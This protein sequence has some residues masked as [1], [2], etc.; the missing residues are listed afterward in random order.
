VVAE[1]G[2]SYEPRYVTFVE[3][4]PRTAM[5]KIDKKALR[6]AAGRQSELHRD[7]GQR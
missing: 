5:G 6:A 2:E 3:T 7:G 1:L 4:L